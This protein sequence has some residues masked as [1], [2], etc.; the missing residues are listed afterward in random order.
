MK[1]KFY[2]ICSICL[3][4][5]L[6]LSTTWHIKQDGTGNFT[7]IQE[8]I[9][10][11]ANS[12][13]ILVYPGTY[14]ENLVIIEKYM[15]IGSLYLTTGDESYISQTIIDGFQNGSVVLIES[16]PLFYICGFVIQNGI[17]YQYNY[18]YSPDR[19]G[20]GM[21]ISESQISL[22]GCIIQ[23]N[24]ANSIGGGI[25]LCNSYMN[26]T[27]STIRNN[28]AHHAA[29]GLLIGSTSSSVSFDSENLN[30]IYL[31][32]AGV[33]NDIFITHGSPYQEI[34]VD[35]FTVIDPAEGYY[36]I[37][38]SSGG[39]G[40]PM[41][42]HF[43]VEIQNAVVEQVN[44]DLYVSSDGDNNN[45]GT[46]AAEPLQSIAYA[47]IK[48][49]S[50]SLFHKTIHIANGVYSQSLNDQYFP[51]H[52]KSYIDIVGE[53]RENTILDAELNGG[54]FYGEDPQ[55]DY[56]IKNLSL[57]NSRNQ[58]DL[59]LNE[60][61]GVLFENI[62]ISNHHDIN[63]C[64]NSIKLN[65]NDISI[66]NLTVENN[67][68]AGSV[69]FYS[70]KYGSEFNISNSIFRNNASSA[71]GC[72]QLFCY[73]S[74]TSSDSLIINILNTEIT[75]NLDNGFEWTPRTSALLIDWNSKVN[76][77]NSTIG[78]NITL[79]QGAAVQLRFYSKAN[80][81]NSILYGNI[82][83]QLCLNSTSGPTTL[84]ANNSLIQDG[85]PG[86]LQIGNNFIN[87]DD[88]TMLDE[89][90]LWLGLGADWP[91]ALS[92]DSPCIDTGTIDLPYGVE[93]P[94]YD[95]AGNPRVCGNG[96]DMGAYE[97]PGN[98]API[99]LEI[100]NATLFWQMPA[101]FNATGYNVYLDDEY[102]STVSAFLNEYTFNDLIIGNSYTAGVS[103]LYGT[104]ETV[105]INLEFIYDPVNSE[106]E[107]SITQLQI[108]NYPNPFNPRTTI[109]CNLIESGNVELAIY[110]IKGQKVKTLLDCY[111]SPGRSEMIWNG[112]DDNGKRVSSGIYFYQFVTDKK[113]IT[114]KM[115][116]I[117]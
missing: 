41:P 26:L 23:Y 25:A 90:P 74:G 11:C 81:V 21:Y 14:F 19:T 99:N 62:I 4:S 113:T 44:C 39:A 9:D 32:Y 45:S 55:S 24:N 5:T 37:Y 79:E 111:M 31:N 29:G 89:D 51:L 13:T 34:I 108:T 43:S 53:S 85:L 27:G 15:T 103:A 101:G 12:D 93:L 94:A 60:N 46:S 3:L 61:T 64:F 7:T 16:A 28:S 87:W 18:P 71:I 38:P 42:D 105:I 88:E 84:N 92:A 69:Y 86:I 109:K 50:D 75:N 20:G 67:L 56:R 82:T 104:E 100:Y 70:T 76:I 59:D 73:R 48:I 83:H 36:F 2:F 97:F 116:L 115:I 72:L 40:F 112:R 22:E 117:K 1:L 102:Q 65:F 78:N 63:A 98:A 54:F 66:N 8:G 47:L 106:E 30:S 6:L 110:N 114:K 17:G 107:I 95:L 10:A 35:T 68:F 33:G 96:I 77:I 91:Y 52:I 80:I 49:R 57:I 58:H